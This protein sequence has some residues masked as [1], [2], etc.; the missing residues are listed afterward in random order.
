MHP[1]QLAGVHLDRQPEVLL[2]HPPALSVIAAVDLHREPPCNDPLR[3]VFSA[4]AVAAGGS[5]RLRA[6]EHIFDEVAPRPG[7]LGLRQGQNRQP[8]QPAGQRLDAPG[9]SLVTRRPGHHEPA[10]G[11]I[12]VE[13]GLYVV[14]YLRHPLVFV[15]EHRTG[16]GNRRVGVVSDLQPGTRVVEINDIPAKAPGYL[17]EQGGLA[18]H[19]RPLQHHHRKAAHGLER[20]IE[21]P[22][23]EHRPPRHPRLLPISDPETP[24]LLRIIGIFPRN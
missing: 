12:D 16:S 17:L 2:D 8:E 6:I 11:P 9:Q 14:E 4:G 1:Q 7:Y 23:P 3:I 20:P 19:P 5:E 21:H 15:D 13:P 18:H 10:G 22:P 24:G